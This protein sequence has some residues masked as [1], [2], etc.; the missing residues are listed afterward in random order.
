MSEKSN[1]GDQNT[2]P[3]GAG[4]SGFP[5]SPDTLPDDATWK[6][7]QEFSLQKLDATTVSFKELL[8]PDQET[9]TVLVIFSM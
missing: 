4:V 8:A 5:P 1:S 7:A 2:I 9:D 6:K 3:S